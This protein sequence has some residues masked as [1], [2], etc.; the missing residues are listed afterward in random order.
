MC[1]YWVGCAEQGGGAGGGAGLGEA[2]P[3]GWFGTE[4]QFGFMY[5]D[6][7]EENHR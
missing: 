6:T 5:I 4:Q 3:V 1:Q 2:K 7:L